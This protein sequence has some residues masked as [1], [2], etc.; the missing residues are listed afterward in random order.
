MYIP[1]QCIILYHDIDRLRG[2]P[3]LALNW[4]HHPSTHIDTQSLDL[5]SLFPEAAI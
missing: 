2:V 4:W 1:Y 5:Q 3:N